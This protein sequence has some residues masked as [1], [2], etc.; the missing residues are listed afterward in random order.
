MQLFVRTLTGKTI[1]IEVEPFDSIDAIK[2]KIQVKEG[3]PV[4]RMR[5]I[6]V[7]VQLENARLAAD[8]HLAKGDT[9]HL[10]GSLRGG[11]APDASATV[12]DGIQEI[13]GD[14][15]LIDGST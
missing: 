4:G 7:G 13:E 12:G 14:A 11:T 2:T 1:T 9:L 10:L 5:L 8:Y 6:C 15:L 3:I